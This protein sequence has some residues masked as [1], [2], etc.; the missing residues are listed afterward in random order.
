MQVWSNLQAQ[1]RRVAFLLFGRFSNLCLANAVEPLRAANT[2]AARQLFSWRFLTLDG[3]TVPASSGIPVAPNAMLDG[4]EEGDALFII[5]GYDYRRHATHECIAALRA[6]ARRYK[7]LVGLDTCSGLLAEAGLLRG[8]GATIHWEVLEPFAERFPEMDVRREHYVI[9]RDRITCGGGMIAF[10][11]ALTLIGQWYGEALRVDVASHF[12]H[13]ATQ[14]SSEF[15]SRSAKSRSVVRAMALMREYIENP[16]PVPEIARRAGR[17]QRDLAARFW[18][19]LGA[20]PRTVYQHLRLTQARKLV[21]ETDFSVSEIAVRCGY[22]DASAMTRAFR[23]QFGCSPS[24]LRLRNNED[25]KARR[26]S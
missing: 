9:D 7:I 3:K 21:E 1:S 22:G 18:R 10:E 17:T 16:L 19:E 2:I 4:A 6:A 14:G 25:V 13:E 23:G 26:S 12:M 24:A 5:T 11:L 15:A 8:Y 20:S